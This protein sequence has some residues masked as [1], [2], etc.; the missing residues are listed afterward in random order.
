METYIMPSI[1]AVCCVLAFAFKTATHND[2]IHDFIPLGCAC[3]GIALAC[4]FLGMSL[5]SLAAGAV[6][7]LAAT[8]LWEQ[9]THIMPS[10]EGD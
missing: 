2:R 5:D 1:A 3:L 4:A 8:G 9:A 10:T 6:S 7:G